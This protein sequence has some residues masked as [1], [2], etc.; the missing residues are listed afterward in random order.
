[1]RLLVLNNLYPPQELGGY[2]RSLFDFAN[3]LRALGHQIQVLTSN[4]PY[5]DGDIGDEIGVCRNLLLL[6]S[7][8]NG[9][10]LLNNAGDI[11]TRNVQNYRLLEQFMRTFQPQA[12]LVG[13]IDLL[14]PTLLHQLVAAGIHVWHHFGFANANVEID[15]LPLSSPLYHPLGG[16]QHTAS[17]LQLAISSGSNVPVIYTGA[18][19]W[20][21]ASLLSTPLSVPLKIAYAGL[22]I[23]SKGPQ[24]LLDAL[25]R[26]KSL[27]IAFNAEFAGAEF[28]VDGLN[29]FQRYVADAD[30]ANH[31]QFLGRL[32]RDTLAEFYA[33][34]Q[35]LVFPSIHPEGFGIVQVEAMAA[36]LLVISSGSG[37]A[38]ETVYD[39]VNGRRF[40]A[41]DGAHLAEVLQDVISNPARHEQ[42]RKRARRVACRCFDVGASSL[43]LASLMQASLD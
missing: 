39:D 12:A 11:H 25:I 38:A 8:E 14:N 1:M 13:N 32:D 41:G 15:Q 30:I 5:L 31:V 29:P 26:L 37:G 18:Q 17:A 7:Y 21:F 40:R 24:V 33:R 4:A 36:G 23:G 42:L 2:G 27:G 22:M 43:K 19:T 35:I 3:E 34:H 10:Q 28:G 6:G 9:L 16:S 20:R